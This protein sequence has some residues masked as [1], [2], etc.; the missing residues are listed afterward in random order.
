MFSGKIIQVFCRKELL[1]SIK[2][3]SVIGD[4]LYVPMIGHTVGA[5][6][7][8]DYKIRVTLGFL[9]YIKIKIEWQPSFYCTNAQLKRLQLNVHGVLWPT[10]SQ[11]SAQNWFSKLIKA[12]LRICLLTIPIYACS[13]RSSCAEWGTGV[14]DTRFLPKSREETFQRG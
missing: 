13:P 11:L 1:I 4:S 12:L 2:S 8:N 10:D 3:S 6:Y 7:R 14:Q 9:I 5:L